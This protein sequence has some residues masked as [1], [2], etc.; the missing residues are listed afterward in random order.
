M[1]DS[2]A[3]PEPL[4]QWVASVVGPIQEVRDA[5]HARENSRVWEVTSPTGRHFVKIAPQPLSYT[6]ETYA[7]RAAV[8]HL[9]LGNAP[10]LKASSADLCAMILTAVDGEPLKAEAS[11]SR[12]RAAHAQAGLLLRRFHDAAPDSNVLAQVGH[13]IENTA[14]GLDR[15]LTAAGDHLT[16]LEADILRRHVAVLL[17]LEDLPVGLLHGDLWERNLLWNGWRCALIDFERSMPGPL[18]ADFVKLATAVWPE[19]P[20]LRSSFFNGYGRAL[21]DAEERALVAFSAAD[22]ASALAYGPR[23][24]DPQVTARGRRTVDRLTREARR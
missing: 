21:S 8:P 1:T 22:A 12:R 4:A 18:V 7:Y 16:A 9:G 2:A 15:H 10:V 6:R 23:H 11:P 13:V 19:F 5:S 3:L 20:G 14:A 24:G 17:D